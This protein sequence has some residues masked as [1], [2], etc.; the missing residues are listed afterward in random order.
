MKRRPVA[1]EL[2]A[3]TRGIAERVGA[4]R[5]G[6][7]QHAV[8][9]ENRIAD[10]AL[11]E[12]PRVSVGTAAHA[13]DVAVRGPAPRRDRA[14]DRLQPLLVYEAHAASLTAGWPWTRCSASSVA[15]HALA[16]S[17]A[18]RST[19]GDTDLASLMNAEAAAT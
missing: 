3:D 7:H 15:V 17:S 10:E 13:R 5:A 9:A 4:D 1:L 18:A 16:L 2:R 6:S 14:D 8:R 19:S 11:V 12:R